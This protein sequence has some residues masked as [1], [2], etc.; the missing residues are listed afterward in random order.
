MKKAFNFIGSG[1]GKGIVWFFSIVILI[2]ILSQLALWAGLQWLNSDKG[3]AWTQSQINI[4]LKDSDYKINLSGFKYYP[5]TKL[6][7]KELEVSDANGVIA[8][9]E[10]T[11]VGISI[12]SLAMRDLSLSLKANKMTLHRLPEAEVKEKK[13]TSEVYLDAFS[14]PNLYFNQ[15]NIS[16]ISIENLEVSEAV[17]GQAMVLSPSISGGLSISENVVDVDLSLKP[18]ARNISQIPYLPNMIQIEGRFDSDKALLTLKAFD[19]NSDMYSLSAQGEA[20]LLEGGVINL[21]ANIKGEDLKKLSADLEGDV[22]VDIKLSGT[23][24]NLSL[25]ADG[26]AVLPALKV[27]G[28]EDII[29]KAQSQYSL[30]NAYDI[31]PIS[32]SVASAYQ[33]IPVRLG[34]NIQKTES[35]IQVKEIL[36]SAPDLQITGAV[37]YN[38]EALLAEGSVKGSI[39]KFSTYKDLLQMDVAGKGGFELVL[40]GQ[41]AKQKAEIKLTG[42]QIK[43][44][45]VEVQDALVSAAFPTIDN[46]WPTKADW[47]LKGVKTAGLNVS[48]ISGTIREKTKDIFALQTQGSGDFDMPFSFDVNADLISLKTATPTAQNIKGAV[49]LNNQD[50]FITGKVNQENIDVKIN[51]KSVSLNKLINGLPEKIK[52]TSINGDVDIVGPMTAPVIKSDIVLS[53]FSLGKKTPDINIEMSGTYEDQL[54]QL[55]VTGKG[56]GIKALKVDVTTPITVSLYPFLLDMPATQNLSGDVTLHLDVGVLSTI[57]LPPHYD[58][59]GVFQSDL[60]IG[61]SI[62]NPKLEGGFNLSESKFSDENLGVH[63]Q[64]I[65]ANGRIQNDRITLQSFSAKDNKAGTLNASGYVA[66]DQYVPN[67]ILLSLDVKNFHL[68]D[69]ELADGTFNGD[70]KLSGAGQRFNLTGTVRP[71]YI[72]INIPEKLVGSIPELNIVEAEGGNKNDT[73]MAQ[74][75]LAIN[76]IADNKIF[77]RGWGLDAEFGG[78][79]KIDGNLD[80]PNFNGTLKSLRGRYTE[81]GKRFE[82]ARANLNFLGRIPANPIMDIV[83]ETEVEDITAQV[84]L[85]GTVQD[86]KITFTSNPSLPEDEVLARILFGRDLSSISPFQAVQLAQTVRR[87]SGKGGGF[88][89]LSKIRDVTGLDDLRVDTDEDGQATVG[90]GKYLTDKVYLEF[91]KGSGENSGAANLEVEVTPNI[92]LESKVGEDAQAGAGLFWEWDY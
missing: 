4:A 72:D 58:F 38:L 45:D 30:V 10:N 41:D 92:T 27:R 36:G 23:Q 29:F 71:N 7:V 53:A 3:E 18:D 14:L 64:N 85:T 48:T 44:Q 17:S 68:L 12:V 88:D 25:N 86:P 9:A 21:N 65:N 49:K 51:A 91:E 82:L 60:N 5:L 31:K 56:Q 83:A 74:V 78:R 62:E 33:K 22:G 47:T 52:R 76:F 11:R 34:A 90:A 19:V 61:G 26:K 89:P 87:F 42:T 32:L 70:L 50:I 69:G 37:N 63:L 15:L 54:V 46:V 79:L 59:S 40:T 77:V 13:T 81:F 73:M 6:V 75:S 35:V 66:L 28:L 20:V 39:E 67:D 55:G 2:V 24:D 80:D 43:Y 8:S 84:N 16:E 1:L 57:L